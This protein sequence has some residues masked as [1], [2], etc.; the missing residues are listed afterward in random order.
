M[1]NMSQSGPNAFDFDQRAIT[2][3]YTAI[4]KGVKSIMAQQAGNS[5]SNIRTLDLSKPR[6][7]A[8]PEPFIQSTESASPAATEQGASHQAASSTTAKH[9]SPIRTIDLKKPR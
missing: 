9:S 3:R 7:S 1:P 2:N 6:Y 4:Q 5:S 8:P